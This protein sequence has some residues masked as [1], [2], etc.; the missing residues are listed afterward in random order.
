MIAEAAWTVED[1]RKRIRASQM[2]KRRQR[3]PR[4]CVIELA[5]YVQAP[6]SAER[7]A[8]LVMREV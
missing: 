3:P 2:E 8:G 1:F 7:P 5:C 6:V 4:P